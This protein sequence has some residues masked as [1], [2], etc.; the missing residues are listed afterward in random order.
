MLDRNRV[1]AKRA[2]VQGLSMHLI[3]AVVQNHD[4]DM[5]F[6]RLADEG[7]GATRIGSSGGF[8]RHANATI[9]I[10]VE[11]ERLDDA[12]AILRVTCGR[13]IHR[14]PAWTVDSSEADFSAVSPTEQG[15]GIFFVM[16]VDRFERLERR[17]I[18]GI[19]T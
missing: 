2:P 6:R 7:I 18:A 8:L 16:P 19:A 5:L 13:R 17:E 11:R 3:F 1:G 10:G 12:I 4:A 15:G 14:A 9:F